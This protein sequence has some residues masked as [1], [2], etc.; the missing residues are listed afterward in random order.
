MQ[1]SYIGS[2]AKLYR[3]VSPPPIRLILS[4]LDGWCFILLIA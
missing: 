1:Q 4:A 3:F 2:P